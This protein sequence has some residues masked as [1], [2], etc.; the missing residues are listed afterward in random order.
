MMR[1]IIKESRGHPFYNSKGNAQ[2]ELPCSVCSLKS[3]D[4]LIIPS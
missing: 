3:F 4:C 2:G 1:H